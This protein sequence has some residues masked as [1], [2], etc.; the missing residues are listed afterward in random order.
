MDCGVLPT[1]IKCSHVK[2]IFKNGERSSPKNYRPISLISHLGKIFERLVVKNLTEYLN[3]LDLFNKQ[4]HGFRSGRSCL[5]QLLEHH[6]KV[7]AGLEAGS[8]VDVVYLD[9]AKAF[10]KV[11]YSILLAKLNAIGISGKLLRWIHSFLTERKQAVKIGGNLSS[12]GPVTS[13][14]P[15][16]SSLGPLLFLIHISDIDINTKHAMV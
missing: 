16:G 5:S 15:Q 13:G 9:F 2:P 10:D 12:E 14:V 7:L 6:Q 3:S 1:K 8:S 11:D 4:Q